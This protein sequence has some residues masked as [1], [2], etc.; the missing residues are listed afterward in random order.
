[1]RRPIGFRQAQEHTLSAEAELG[2]VVIDQLSQFTGIKAAETFFELL[3]LHLQLGDLLKQL[4]HLDLSLLLIVA[5]LTPGEELICSVQQ[6]PLQLAHLDRG[7]WRNP[8][9]PRKTRHVVYSV[10]CGLLQPSTPT[11]ITAVMPKQVE[12]GEPMFTKKA[13]RANPK[14]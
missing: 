7:G 4:G 10:V 2:V 8:P 9:L 11:S 12:S 14:P 5:R 3:Q 6:L 1:M 13:R